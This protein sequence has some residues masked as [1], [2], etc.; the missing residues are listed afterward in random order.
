MTEHIVLVLYHL[1]TGLLQVS[2][3]RRAC[4]ACNMLYIAGD[5]IPNA[6]P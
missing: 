6:V 4:L 2:S 3:M 1:S 5:S